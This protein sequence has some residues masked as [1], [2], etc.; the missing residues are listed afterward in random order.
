M[1]YGVLVSINLAF[2]MTK[3]R[4][5]QLLRRSVTCTK[6]GEAEFQQQSNFK[7]FSFSFSPAQA[8]LTESSLKKK[9]KKKVY[10]KGVLETTW[11]GCL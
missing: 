1:S 10:S 2:H 6:S 5:L 11:S 3:A 9:K 7:G 4:I 8:T